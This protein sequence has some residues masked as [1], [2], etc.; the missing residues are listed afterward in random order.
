MKKLLRK[1]KGITL[2]ALVI[3]IVVM[4]ILLGIVLRLTLGEN[5]VLT[6]AQE[7]NFRAEM[8]KVKEAVNMRMAANIVAE[9]SNAEKVEYDPVKLDDTDNWKATLKEEIVNFRDDEEFSNLDIN[10]VTKSYLKKHFKELLADGENIRGLYYVKEEGFDEYKYIYDK[11]S[12]IVYKIP[13]TRV[14]FYIVHSVE[15]LDYLKT[16]V[17][18][19]IVKKQEFTPITQTAS[20]KKVGNVICY[21]PDLN[22]LTEE[23]IKLVFYKLNGTNVTTTKIEKTVSEWIEAGKPNEIIEG[24]NKYVLYDYENK[25]WANIKVVNTQGTE[26]TKD[27]VEG[28]WTWI[29][30]Y[31]YKNT[32]TTTDIVFINIGDNIA[33]ETEDDITDDVALPEAYSVA[34]IFNGNTKKGIWVS[35]YEHITKSTTNTGEWQYYIPDMT[36]LDKNTTELA[37]YNDNATR[38]VE[39]KKLSEVDSLNKFAKDNN[40]FDYYNQKWANIRIIN[41]QGTED[42]KD[43]LESWWVWIPRYAYSNLGGTTDIIFVDTD[44]Q[45]MDGSMLPTSYSIP[46][47]FK[48]N[49]KKGIWISK[50]E[51]ITKSTV[52]PQNI[53]TVPDLTG[54]IS[55]NVKVYL[56]TYNDTKTRFNSNL[57]EYNSSLDL[58]KFARENSWYDYS[59]QAW[60]NIKVVNTLGTPETSDDLEGW[61]VWIPRYAYKNT[62]ATTEILLIG[63]DNKTL[64]NKE[65]PKGYEILEIFKGN[66][67][68]GIWI[69][70]YELIQ[71]Q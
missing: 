46:E 70:K 71:K 50:Y 59:K 45:P 28:W 13:S 68:K 5:G 14:G 62:G 51:H 69:S 47:I 48:G 30:R 7:S 19:E 38:F 1:S 32:D 61:W 24:T 4:L 21:E 40:W 55:P 20:M 2:I 60:A 16:K 22:G 53:N 66:T 33:D 34:E 31:A 64:D 44:N 63:T 3:T 36:G 12:D 29:P 58:E 43:D 39:Y 26:D 49:N 6:K 65:L 8:A 17:K 10:E 57:T 11:E 37:I 54:L 52:E 56:A 25:I 67:K 42:T 18:P 35:K 15:Q 41:N 23:T 27:D 9:K